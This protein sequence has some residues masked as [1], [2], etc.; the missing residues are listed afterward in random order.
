MF[1]PDELMAKLTVEKVVGYLKVIH[2]RNGVTAGDLLLAEWRNVVA[3]EVNAAREAL[4]AIF[5][6]VR[7]RR[8]AVEPDELARQLETMTSRVLR[9]LYPSQSVSSLPH[10][11][12]YE[13]L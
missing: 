7:E 5:A 8:D 4:G 3:A 10:G 2:Q 1:V 11:L 13:R 9:T 12:T 6:T